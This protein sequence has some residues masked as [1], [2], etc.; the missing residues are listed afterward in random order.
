[1]SMDA[2]RGHDASAEVRGYP[3]RRTVLRGVGGFGLAA[4][5]AARWAPA[6]AQDA[7]PPPSGAVGV[8]VQV[9]GTGLPSASPGLALTL[10]RLTIAPGGRLPAHSHPGALVIFVEAGTWG[11]TV[12]G[13]VAQLTRAAVG[14]TPTP[15][16]E[17]PVGTEVIL[18]PGDWISIEDPQDEFRNAGEE[19]V[20]LV[21]AN[22]AKVGEPFTTLMEMEGMDMGK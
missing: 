15:T 16:E 13:G 9:L 11:Y 5:F 4:L 20:V 2:F 18:G 3:S 21:S 17:M 1:M 14:G 12:L 7:T 22:L 8:T 19:D 10:R 6:A